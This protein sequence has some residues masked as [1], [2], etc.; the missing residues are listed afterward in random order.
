MVRL[1]HNMKFTV[2]ICWQYIYYSYVVLKLINATCKFHNYFGQLVYYF[3]YLH[4][5]AFPPN[6]LWTKWWIFMKFD[7]DMPLEAGPY[8]YFF[9]PWHNTRM[10]EYQIIW[11]ENITMSHII[12]F[13]MPRGNRAGNI[14]NFC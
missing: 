4:L 14:S 10:S 8:L 7:T 12:G 9:I 6:N 2:T 13:K 3:P 1:D 5:C 11:G